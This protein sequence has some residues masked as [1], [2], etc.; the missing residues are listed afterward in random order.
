MYVDVIQLLVLAK[1]V[2]E[3]ET[4][5][6]RIYSQDIRMEF[7]IEKYVILIMKNGKRLITEEIKLPNQE[8]IRTLGA[9]EKF[10]VLGKIGIIW[11]KRRWKK[12]KKRIR[13]MNENISWNHTLQ[14]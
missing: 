12:N 4:Q 7:G 9:K 14:Q 3:S 1:N 2:R 6:I 8:R 5:I 10:Q 13:Q 11:K